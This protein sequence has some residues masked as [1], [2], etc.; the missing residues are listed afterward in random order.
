M[1]QTNE[2][3][4]TRLRSASDFMSPADIIYPAPV[5]APAGGE[6]APILPPAVDEQTLLLSNGRTI[7]VIATLSAVNFLS[8]FSNG[9][10]T[11]GLPRMALDIGLPD[12][13]IAW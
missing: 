12:Y 6:I 5:A 10:L 1:S 3:H 9:L 8:S 11:I 7:I 4:I 13:L 2:I